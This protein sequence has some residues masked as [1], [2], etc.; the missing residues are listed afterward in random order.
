MET[1]S[2]RERSW[3][4]SS[5]EWVQ[6]RSSRNESPAVDQRQRPSGLKKVWIYDSVYFTGY[7]LVQH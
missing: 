3:N 1:G 6:Y 5:F 4:Y 7:V 2:V